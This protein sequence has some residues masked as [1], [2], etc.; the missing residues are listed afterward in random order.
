MHQPL[1][2]LSLAYK[3]PVMHHELT[4]MQEREQQIPGSV[5][6][7]IKRYQR[8]QQRNLDEAGMM[9]YHY[10]KND[11]KD[12]YLELRF[13]VSGNVYCRENNVRC[14]LCKTSPS[15]NCNGRVDSVDVLSFQFST[16][17]LSQFVKP[18]KLSDTL[19]ND[20]LHFNHKSSFTKILP[21]CGRTRLVL[22][23]L[24]NHSY[25]DSLE[26]IYINAQTQ[27][28][29]LYSLECMVG[30]KE[31]E[32]FPAGFYLTKP[33]GKKYPKP[34]RYCCSILVNLSP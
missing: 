34:G 3:Q 29:L 24:L 23:G 33:T 21:L 31:I 28:L 8:N 10:K 5:Q 7:V 14:D 2:I 9:I 32:S 26:N 22:E 30:D 27:M 25:K 11:T 20:I 13:C 16:V 6:Y 4:L 18:L 1:D 12:N 17:H 19:T 15:R